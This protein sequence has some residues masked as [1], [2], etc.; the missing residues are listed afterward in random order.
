MALPKLSPSI[1]D[2]QVDRFASNRSWPRGWLAL[3]ALGFIFT[4]YGQLGF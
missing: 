3:A 2:R 4:N 1:T